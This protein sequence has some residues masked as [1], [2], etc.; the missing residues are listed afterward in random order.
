MQKNTATAC[1]LFLAEQS[2]AC[3]RTWINVG[4]LLIN[5]MMKNAV[6][7]II[8]APNVLQLF[9]HSV[10]DGVRFANDLQLMCVIPLA[11]PDP[12]IR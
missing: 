9:W 2:I 6:V 10:F 11:S 4:S 1:K 3:K 8:F 12:I 5:I 7:Y